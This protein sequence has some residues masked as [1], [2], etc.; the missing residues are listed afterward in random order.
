M[1]KFKVVLLEHGYSTIQYERDIV[2]AAGGEFVDAESFGPEKALGLC[3]DAD[4][5]LFRRIEMTAELI[6]RLGKCKVI[7]RYGVGTDNVNVQAATEAGIIVGHVP[8]YCLDE[9]SSH[10]IGLLLA[11]VRRIVR[12]H[13]KMERGE[14]DVHRNEPVWRT[15]GKTLGLVGF[16]QIGQAVARKLAGWG[17]RI[18]AHDPFVESA[19]VELVDLETLC[20]ESDYISIH[21]PLLPETRHSIG[22]KQFALMKQGVILVNTA[23]G[24]L[25]DT[26]ALLEAL[27]AGTVVQA[28]LDV[29]EEEPLPANSILRSH[30]QIIVTD[31]VGWYSEES[32]IELQKTAAREA[33]AVCLGGLPR[34]M[35]NPEVLFKLGRFEEWTPSPTAQWQIKR[36]Q[37]MRGKL[38]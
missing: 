21:A 7:V 11:C 35:A 34:S 4:A 32:Q 18:L 38:G 1:A 5:V 16:G 36:M 29:F 33:V 37:R 22:A 28:A 6:R 2:T 27:D 30:P 12:T 20:R 24:P 17:L 31:H 23:R 10:A 19:P 3:E 25:V 26:Q 8:S 9:V 15:A 14:W 13:Q